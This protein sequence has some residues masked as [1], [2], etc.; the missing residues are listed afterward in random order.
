MAP[1]IG[2]AAVQSTTRV[3]GGLTNTTYR[4]IATEGA[5]YG[6]RVYAAGRAAL[7]LER[8][9]LPA[10]SAAIPVPDVL[11]ADAG[12]AH[13]Y[14][15]YGW[16][17]G[18]TLNECRRDTGP[19][20]LLTLAQPLGRIVAR[21]SG[22]ALSSGLDPGLDETRIDARLAEADARLG[23]GL[24]RERLG[25]ALADGLRAK[26]AANAVRLQA[27]EHPA[28]LVHGDVGGRNVLV[29][30]VADGGWAV[31]G[32]IDWESASTGSATWDV[33]SLFRYPRRYSPEFRAGFERG[34]RAAGGEL[35]DD[36]WAAARLLDST[37]LVSILAAPRELPS[38]F[39]ECRELIAAIV[40]VG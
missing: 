8:R 3:E 29:R 39:T 27:L 20:A 6:L 33:G 11:F 31:C 28:G 40:A 5:A 10:L 13:P 2:M 1:V 38:V 24:A 14:L 7:D 34:Y 18:I 12:G 9:L 22:V 17:E 26:L 30:R 23:N 4:V 25:P 37:R 32:V 21:V 35:A 16:I 15:V 19:A 36:W